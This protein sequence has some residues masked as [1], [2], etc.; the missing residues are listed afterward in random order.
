MNFPCFNCDIINR[1]LTWTL[2][3]RLW[4][5]MLL[6]I[7]I[8]RFSGDYIHL[9]TCKNITEVLNTKIVQ[10]ILLNCVLLYNIME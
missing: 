9:C 5:E 1:S 8:T 6:V 4:T 2:L 10:Y 7:I 3:L